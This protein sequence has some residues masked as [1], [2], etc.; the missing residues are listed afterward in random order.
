MKLALIEEKVEQTIRKNTATS[1]GLTLVIGLPFPAEISTRI[2]S[3]QQQLEA[4]APGRFTWYGLDHVHATLVALLRG[5]YRDFPP[6]QREELPADLQGFTQ[7]LAGFFAQHQPFVLELA[8]LHISDNGLVL[9]GQNTFEQQLASS[10]KEYPELDQPKHPGGLHA[11]IGYCNTNRPFTTDEEI[12][13]LEAALSEF[14]RIPIGS[15]TVGQVWL[16]HYTN[17]TLNRIIG[18]VPFVLGQ[19]NTLTGRRLLQELDIEDSRPGNS[20]HSN[21]Q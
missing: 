3:L 15:M 21:R 20:A 17:R 7:D 6:L 14:I 12:A 4:L 16:V 18:K 9:V 10:L 11:A 2:Q 8:G 19:A 1:Y 5:R 13:P